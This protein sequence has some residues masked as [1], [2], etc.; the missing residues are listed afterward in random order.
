M[1][2]NKKGN[3]GLA[4]LLGLIFA[5]V[6]V[7]FVQAA[8]ITFTGYT[9]ET[10]Y[11]TP[12]S[13]GNITTVGGKA[14]IKVDNLPVGAIVK[15][16]DQSSGGKLLGSS[17]VKT[18][19]SATVSLSSLSSNVYVSV[20]LESVR[21]EISIGQSTKLTDLNTVVKNNAGISDTVTVT[22]VSVGDIVKVY[23]ALTEGQV[24]GTATVAKA[25]D[26]AVVSIKQLGTTAG[27]IYV[28]LK[29]LG[30][31]E[32]ER[33]AI[34]YDEELV[35][36]ALIIGSS[37][38][39][40]N[41]GVSDTVTVTG[42]SAGDVVKVYDASTEGQVLGTATVAKAK[43]VAVVSIKQL[44]PEAGSI[45]VS[46]KKVGENEATT[47]LKTDYIAEP[48]TYELADHNIDIKNN[49]G[50]ADTVT[51]TD[52]TSGDIV[53]VYD[54]PAKTILL[55]KATVAKGKTEA[56]ASIKQLGIASGNVS[57]TVTS[58]GERESETYEKGYLK[59]EQTEPLEVGQINVI[60]NSGTADKV[61]VTGLEVGDIVKVYDAAGT[62]LL[63][64]ATVA[65][66]KT[67]A[68]ISISQLGTAIGTVKVS[69][70]S[71][72]MR[73][74]D[75]VAKGYDEEDQSS[76]P[77][78]SDISIANSLTANDKVTVAGL[79]VG[80]IV[81][82][83][84]TS[85]GGILWGKAT[86]ASGETQA[87]VTIRQLGSGA[88]TVWVTVTSSGKLESSRTEQTYLAE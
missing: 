40:N 25:K 47:R 34:N 85:T 21:S 16:Y 27:S 78:L 53:K 48:Q 86:V 66:D 60:N 74:S 50:V 5:L 71:I 32:S 80:D 46:L 79:A 4:L 84:K 45:Y 81:K 56:V 49:A 39:V 36:D 58:P 55:G 42:L 69:V 68:V 30:S 64:K 11:S 59:E 37:I 20:T 23:D 22:G 31:T 13:I 70:T 67:E 1:L 14:S 8:E 26:V 57:V 88:G 28:S 6:P 82:V 10:A 76:S 87:E 33:S 7:S 17:T 44:G 29:T 54:S 15:V 51:V 73:E 9:A 3:F 35:T 38:A 52:L 83:Y 24:L 75:P 63:G 65:K 19:T 12:I 77:N 43:D 72:G 2:R 41:A 61:T 62:K 18:G